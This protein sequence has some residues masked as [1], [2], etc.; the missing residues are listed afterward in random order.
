MTLYDQ[1]LANRVRATQLI[2]QQLKD[3]RRRFLDYLAPGNLSVGFYLVVNDA[4]VIA[5]IES[6]I[7]NRGVYQSTL[8]AAKIAFLPLVIP[9]LG[10]IILTVAS[11]QERGAFPD[12]YIDPI[13]KAIYTMPIP[14]PIGLAPQSVILELPQLQDYLGGIDEFQAAFHHGAFKESGV[15]RNSQGRFE[16]ARVN[17]AIETVPSERL[18]TKIPKARYRYWRLLYEGQ[19]KYTYL[20]PVSSDVK[21]FPIEGTFEDT[22]GARLAA[23]Q[24][25]KPGGAP[26]WILLEFGQFNWSPK[27]RISEHFSGVGKLRGGQRLSGIGAGGIGNLVNPTPNNIVLPG[28]ITGKWVNELSREWTIAVTNAWNSAIVQ[29][30]GSRAFDFSPTTT[31]AYG[32]G[33]QGVG[34]AHVGGLTKVISKQYGAF[35]FSYAEIIQNTIGRY[36]NLNGKLVD[37]ASLEIYRMGK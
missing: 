36:F 11:Q 25:S 26:Q 6:S 35:Y 31:S 29:T 10:D 12:E 24:R 30:A 33:V 28:N 13:L 9:I 14:E 32:P 15:S 4:D 2:N 23:W 19:R 16:R 34:A 27:I 1:Y 18:L 22:I 8:Q 17:V 5:Q 7:G 37:R 3:N 20:D 21:S